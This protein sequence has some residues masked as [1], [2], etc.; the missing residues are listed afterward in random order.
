MA[1]PG[2]AVRT[3][4]Q[5]ARI[6]GFAGGTEQRLGGQSDGPI[7]VQVSITNSIGTQ[8]SSKVFVTGAKSSDGRKCIV[9]AVDDD[10]KKNGMA[11]NLGTIAVGLTKRV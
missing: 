4:Q 7:T 11:G 5:Q 1:T 6:P 10:H 2:S 9:E 3:K 8:E